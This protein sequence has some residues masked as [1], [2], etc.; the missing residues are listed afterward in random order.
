M[1]RPSV[2]QA[3]FTLVEIMIGLLIGVIGIVVIMQTFAVSEGYKRTATSGTDAQVNGGIA[4]YLMERELRIA[5]FNVTQ[6]A[7]VGCTSVVVW[8]NAT[9]TSVSMRW[10]PVEINPAGYAV[11]DANTDV[12]LIAYGNAD[13]FVSGVP[14][15]QVA[16]NTDR[17]DITANKDG[18][19]AGD[20]VVGVQPGAGAGGAPL[21]VMHELTGVPSAGGNCAVP[22]PPN[23]SYLDHKTSNYK[24]L[25]NLCANTTPTHN[26]AT[27][28]RDPGG[29][30]IPKLTQATG[31]ALYNM[32][33]GPNVKVY[34]IRGGNLTSCDAI[35]KNC[36]VGGNYDIL[37]DN[38]VSMRAIIGGDYVGAPPA[39]STALGDGV[40]DQWSRTAIGSNNDVLRTLAIAVELTSRSTLKEKASNGGTVCDATPDATRPDRAQTTD[41]YQAFS[42]QAVGSLA[43]A[44]I[45]VSGLTDWACYRYKLFQTVVPLRNLVWRP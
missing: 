40:V 13:S 31:A 39:G 38:I 14:V 32:G 43:G 34:A 2:R 21:C 3:G 44:Q 8:N 16:A 12:I 17:L 19:R 30:A 28:I 26:S 27:G 37:V 7:Q 42:G 33:G 11:G 15:N 18:F 45:D 41:W 24:S 9:G 1:N 22:L 36:T 10:V 25:A 5:G 6:L 23:S 20:L 35:A 4:T 29:T